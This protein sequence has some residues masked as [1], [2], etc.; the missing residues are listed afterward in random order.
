ML[1]DDLRP[2]FSIEV[3]F[4]PVPRKLGDPLAFPPF[5]YST[6]GPFF[7]LLYLLPFATTCFFFW[8]RADVAPR[9]VFISSQALGEG[10]LPFPPVSGKAPF[11][12]QVFPSHGSLCCPQGSLFSFDMVNLVRLTFSLPPRDP[13]LA[14]ILPLSLRIWSVSFRIL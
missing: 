13:P 9:T 4:F 10:E 7:L 6:H 14:R 3:L 8:W 11:R 12:F 2:P 1:V 5:S